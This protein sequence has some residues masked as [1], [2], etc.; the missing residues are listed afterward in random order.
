MNN[1]K[2]IFPGHHAPS[3]GIAFG[4]INKKMNARMEQRASQLR[5]VG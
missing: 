1:V 2:F 4:V 3:K 5:S